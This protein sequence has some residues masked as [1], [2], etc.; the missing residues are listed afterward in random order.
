M[1]AIDIPN[2]KKLIVID[3][4]LSPKECESLIARAD[5]IVTNGK[6][7]R[8]WHMADTGGN[9]MRVVMIDEELAG[10]LFR[11]L[12]D[13]IPSSHGNMKLL[14]L[15]PCFR[16]SRYDVGGEFPIHKDGM[17]IDCISAPYH[18]HANT[19]S[20]MTLNIFLNGWDGE[21]DGGGATT[22]FHNDQRTVRY[23]AKPRAGRAALFDAQ[24]YHRGD[25]V[26][27]RY[28]YLLRTDVMGVPM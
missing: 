20:V 7:D 16:F 10:K 13:I 6:G 4:L 3:G 21:G 26:K 1:Q 11:R 2:G 14:Y 28:K 5:Q 19:R 24:Q 12:K 18:G 8:G 9:Y 23:V 25:E 22:F 15:N 17:N 27:R